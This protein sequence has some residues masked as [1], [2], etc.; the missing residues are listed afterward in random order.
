MKERR[1]GVY[2]EN[3]LGRERRDENA[4][5]EEER[6]EKKTEKKLGRKQ[7]KKLRGEGSEVNIG[8]K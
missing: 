3:E 2:Y 5:R 7:E 1:E 4:G 6:K 8:E